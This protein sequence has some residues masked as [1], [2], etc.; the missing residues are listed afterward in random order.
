MPQDEPGFEGRH[1]GARRVLD[2]M[3]PL[4]VFFIGHR[5]HAADAV[6]VAVQELG[7]GVQDDIGA[8]CQRTLQIRTHERIVDHES[9]VGFVTCDLGDR[10]N[11]GERHERVGR[12]FDEHHPGV[13]AHGLPKVSDVGRVEIAELHA[14]VPDHRIEQPKGTAV[15]VV[16]ADGVI[17]GLEKQLR[18]GRLGRHS[19]CEC[20]GTDP[21]FQY[22]HAVFKRLSRRVL[23]SSVLVTLVFS[24]PFLNER[25]SLIDR[26]RNGSGC[27]VGFLSRMYGV[28]SESHFESLASMPERVRRRRKSRISQPVRECYCSGSLLSISAKKSGLTRISRGLLPSGGPTIPSVSIASSRLAARP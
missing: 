17:S 13:G 4:G 5:H 18:D 7:G 8:Q 15:D 14:V 12:C 25:G 2:E 1:D 24:Y 10:L 11:V 28:C 16:G 19:R 20:T 27:R 3:E 21:T 6:A 9:A 26:Y 23:S 22:R